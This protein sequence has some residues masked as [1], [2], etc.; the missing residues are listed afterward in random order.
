MIKGLLSVALATGVTAASLLTAPP[1]QA[2]GGPGDAFSVAGGPA[3]PITLSP[4]TRSEQSYTVTDTATT[5]ERISVAATGLFFEGDAPQFAGSPSAGLSVV[6]SPAS[7]EL[8]PG[9]STA[10]QVQLT[11]AANAR[12]GGLYA[13]LIFRQVPP[14][15][16]GR[17]T[18]IAAQ[19]RP[20][21]GHVPG[22]TTD[23]GIISGFAPPSPPPSPSGPVTFHASFLDT[24][25]I[26]Y[27][28][29]GA[30]TLRSGT[31]IVATVAVAKRRV[32]PGNTRAFPVS[33]AGPVPTG[34]LVADLNLVWGTRAEHSGQVRSEVTLNPLTTGSAP[35]PGVGGRAPAPTFAN[36]PHPRVA[37][38]ATLTSRLLPWIARMGAIALL[39]LALLMLVAL[40]RRRQEEQKD[41]P[42]DAPAV[43]VGA[44]P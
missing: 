13:G 3:G 38:E 5:A 10:I 34:P 26:D 19:A 8:A 9:A 23:S 21:I 16:A 18:V 43:S 27:Q 6:P 29:S 44:A 12:P 37:R 30:A 33:F 1:A 31:H 20:L 14:P 11:V 35:P 42:D 2:V 7:V 39:L 36:G 40:W 22:P 41:Q 32:L 28:L 17:V 25:T 15:E 4:G 24:G